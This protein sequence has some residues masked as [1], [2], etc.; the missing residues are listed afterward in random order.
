MLEVPIIGAGAALGWGVWLSQSPA[1]F[2]LYTA[3]LKESDPA[4]RETVGYLSNR[5]PGYPD[6]LGLVMKA[7]WRR[8]ER[9][10]LE[11]QPVA[12][13]LVA[14]W[15]DGISL[16]RAIEFVTPILHMGGDGSRPAP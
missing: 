6:T 8:I 2:D 5:L 7:H 10:R 12:H 15:R 14:D 1:N 16:K 3:T 9:P 11:P 4:E 13:P